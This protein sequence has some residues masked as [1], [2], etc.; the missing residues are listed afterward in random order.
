MLE[1]VAEVAG[2][3]PLPVPYHQDRATGDF[4]PETGL[5]AWRDAPFELGAACA[6][7]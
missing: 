4:F 6:R 7:G 3:K 2:G 1:A 5:P